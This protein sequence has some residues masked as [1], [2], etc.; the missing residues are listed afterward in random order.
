MAGMPRAWVASTRA[1]GHDPDAMLP[2]SPRARG[3]LFAVVA[4]LIWSIG[5]PVM[6][7]VEAASWTIV[8]W[9]SAGHVLAGPVMLVIL[10][11]REWLRGLL[12]A[13][14]RTVTLTLSLAAVMIFHVLAMGATTVAEVLIVQSITPF[15]VAIFGFLILRE[16]VAMATIG[17]MVVAFAGMAIVIGGGL[18]GSLIG[19][20]YAAIVAATAATAALVVRATRGIDLY[21]ATILSAALCAVIAAVAAPTLWAPGWDIPLL[22]ALGAAQSSVGLV[23]FYGALR[24]LP[25]TEVMLIAMLEPVLGPVWTF[26]F[27][28]EVPPL[29]TMIGGALVLGAVAA[30]T[31]AKRE[32][33]S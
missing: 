16:R 7:S 18:G 13:P 19:A 3:L 11:R 24:R 17:A 6:K 32:T 31:L 30:N 20:A 8:F 4:P 15:L 23:F 27:V 12:S 5:G 25:A 29:T 10:A 22:L 33:P 2:T 28:G 26:F 21:P 14:D 9:R 1:A